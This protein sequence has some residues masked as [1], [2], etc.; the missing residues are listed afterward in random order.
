M[1]KQ[2]S[3]FRTISVCLAIVSAFALFAP[4]A[5]AQSLAIPSRIVQPID[6]ANR[7][8]LTGNTYYLARAQYDVGAA[9][10]TL[11]MERMLLPV[12]YTHLF[13]KH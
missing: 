7:T 3:R 2:P 8:V 1:R 12:S 10:S 9:P 6:E 5:S 4:F 11:P 13:H